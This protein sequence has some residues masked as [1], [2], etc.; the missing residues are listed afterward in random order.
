MTRHLKIK[1]NKSNQRYNNNNRAANLIT[2]PMIVYRYRSKI[3]LI[4]N[5]LL[6]SSCQQLLQSIH[7]LHSQIQLL[8]NNKL[9][10]KIIKNNMWFKKRRVASG[11]KLQL[12]QDKT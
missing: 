8:S 10:L 5:Q 6:L 3:K 4:S 1:L 2:R 7:S 12:E 9:H 11:I